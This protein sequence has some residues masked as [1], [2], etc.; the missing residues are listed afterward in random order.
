MPKAYTQARNQLETPE[1]QKVFREGPTFFELCPIFLNY[2]QK[3]YPGEEEKFSRWASL[4]LRP[5][6]LRACLYTCF[7]HLDKA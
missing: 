5:P 7:V 6:W 3:I 4:P 1:G 2:V